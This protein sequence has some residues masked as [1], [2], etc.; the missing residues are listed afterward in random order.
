V[1]LFIIKVCIVVVLVIPKTAEDDVI[2]GK[3]ILNITLVGGRRSLKHR[4]K[5]NKNFTFFSK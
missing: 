2:K 5:L 3:R 4:S 1:T